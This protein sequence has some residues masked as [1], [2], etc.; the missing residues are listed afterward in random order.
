MGHVMVSSRKLSNEEVEALIEG[1]SRSSTGSE[2]VLLDAES[3][4]VRPF[5]F[6]SDD[7][8][9]L[10]DYYA[11]RMINER[12]SRFARSVFL[13]MLRVQPRIS[14]FPP[15]VKTFD[16]YS[17]SSDNF[18]SL[19]NSRM[20]EL[21]GSQLLVLP[22]NFIS[23]LTNSYYGGTAVRPLKRVQ[24]EFTATEQRVIEI[25]TEGLN[26]ALQLAWRDL[27]AV[28]FSIQSREE[29]IQFASFVDGSETV[30]ICSFMVQLP[31]TEPA[32]FDIIYPLQTLKPIASQLRS[33]VQSDYVDNDLSWRQRLERVIL[34]IPLSLTG[35]LA[36]PT[37]ELHNLIHLQPG[38][39]FPMQILEGVQVLVEG[40][41]MFSAELGQ[42][43]PQAALHLTQRIRETDD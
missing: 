43:G 42:V 8:S 24:G 37:T 40:R 18:V 10:G 19:T 12:F 9:L 38:D 11:L 21:R 6:G 3:P 28:T 39:T 32:I 16:E 35:R 30:I 25:V 36:E 23:L 29:N 15:E 22:P 34:N 20:D 14:S 7:L 5:A 1:L 41:P 13:P 4:G 2:G 31:K 27:T 17:A 33:R 26:E